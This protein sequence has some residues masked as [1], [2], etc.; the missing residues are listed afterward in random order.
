MANAIL[1]N[2]ATLALAEAMKRRRDRVPAAVK[3]AMQRTSL[4]LVS[5]MKV[6]MRSA[7]GT[8]GIRSGNLRNQFTQQTSVNGTVVKTDIGDSVNY[9]RIQEYGGV[10][11]PKH[12]QYLAIPVGPALT[13]AGVSKYKSP[14]DVQGLFVIRSK[15]GKILLVRKDGKQGLV[16]YF[17]LVK[18]VTLKPKLGLR[19]T[20][21]KF[22][23]GI[24]TRFDAEL[25]K[26][27]A[28]VMRGA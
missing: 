13:A 20:M 17:V 3:D 27:V 6:R 15:A 1:T 26:S 14:R 10:I 9:A 16:T 24:G 22:F 28:G 4:A 19:E 7:D 21:R 8:V 2:T 5:D 25:K 11:T 23:V 12:S 18:S